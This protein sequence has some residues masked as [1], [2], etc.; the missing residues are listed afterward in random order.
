M[1]ALPEERPDPVLVIEVNRALREEAM[2]HGAEI[3]GI[4][5]SA[6][7][8]FINLMGY[9]PDSG[10]KARAE[11][12]ARQISGVLK[13]ENYLVADEDLKRAVASAIS[14][15]PGNLVD[16]ISVSAQNGF[17]VLSGD[18]SSVEARMAAEELAGNVPQ[19]RGV[20]NTLQ[21]Q[22]LAVKFPELRALQPPIGARVYATGLVL[23]RVEQ[24]I[25]NE[26]NRLVTEI[27]VEGIFSE[28]SANKRHWFLDDVIVQRRVAIP[29]Y[30]IQHLTDDAVFLDVAAS[31]FEDFD[32]KSSTHPDPNWHPPYPYHRE[33][34]LL[35]NPVASEQ[36][37]PEI[38]GMNQI[39][40]VLA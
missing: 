38:V 31:Q 20:L 40:K 30:A 14:Q 5:V 37:N 13:V 27:L 19:I 18:V 3:K 1:K 28:P 15:I 39:S 6:H 29:V 24:V 25:V 4:H 32:P 12:A 10:Q 21:V 16:G 8:G 23:G 22:G 35:M 11:N 9:V 17:I 26:V 34:V 7:N 36:G 2:V 33:H